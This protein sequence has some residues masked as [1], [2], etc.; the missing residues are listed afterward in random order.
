[1]DELTK[2]RE[3]KTKIEKLAMEV[4]EGQGLPNSERLTT[5]GDPYEGKM[6]EL[7]L[8]SCTFYECFDCKK[9][10][11]GGM[12][13]CQQQLANDESTNKEDYRCSE[14]QIKRYAGRGMGNCS[15]HG[16]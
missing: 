6:L 5:P 1:M 7:A 9:P 4:A 15:T 11:F 8:H 12:A 13:D 2:L 16:K 3:L 14:C 10:Y